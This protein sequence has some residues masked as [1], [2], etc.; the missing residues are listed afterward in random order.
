LYKLLL[1]QTLKQLHKQE[2]VAPGLAGHAQE[3]LIGL[4]LHHIARHLR[5]GGLAERLKHEPLRACAGEIADG[6]PKLPQAL[7][8]AHRNSPSDRKRG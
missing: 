5:D 2:R 1:P 3:R 8:R 6:A 7:I 4:S